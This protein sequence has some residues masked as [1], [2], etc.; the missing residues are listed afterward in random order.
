MGEMVKA[1]PVAGPGLLRVGPEARRL[2][3]GPIIVCG[4]G[5]S[6]GGYFAAPR[7]RSNLT[8]STRRTEVR[9]HTGLAGWSGL[10]QKAIRAN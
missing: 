9:A 8:G 5:L 7:G 1:P 3:P 2:A 4:R 10:I 6:R